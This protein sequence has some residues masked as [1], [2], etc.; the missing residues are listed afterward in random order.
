ML[1]AKKS[2]VIAVGPA[3]RGEGTNRSRRRV[4]LMK[5]RD[6]HGDTN[7][8][9]VI[10][11]RKPEGTSGMAGMKVDTAK[12]FTHAVRMFCD[13]ILDQAWIDDMRH[14]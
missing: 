12:D 3:F 4:V 8:Y 2:D 1:R 9:M 10:T 7:E 6:E 13:H 5:S 14:E 11:R